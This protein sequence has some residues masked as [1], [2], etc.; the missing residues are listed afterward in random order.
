ML[1]RTGAAFCAAL[2]NLN[3]LSERLA[4]GRDDDDYLRRLANAAQVTAI[5]A[6]EAYAGANKKYNHMR[7]AIG[8]GDPP[9]APGGARGRPPKKFFLGQKKF[10]FGG[11][12]GNS[13]E[14]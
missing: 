11:R 4:V 9:P 1:D 12:C 13:Y 2:Q 5:A 14:Y 6:R 10:F 7:R 8:R 3:E